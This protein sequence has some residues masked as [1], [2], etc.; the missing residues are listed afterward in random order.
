MRTWM[1]LA[2]GVVGS[3]LVGCAARSQGPGPSSAP[4]AEP[5]EPRPGEALEVG[6]DVSLR[7][8][9]LA[10]RV[11]WAGLRSAGGAIGGLFRGGPD[12]MERTWDRHTA[13]T[14]D[15][16]RREAERVRDAARKEDP[17]AP[18]QTARR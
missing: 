5:A 6:A 4:A 2:V 17:P 7:S 16:A 3:V 1:V 10:G 11:A 12:E 14:R 8:F 15:L 18:R 13:H 9:A